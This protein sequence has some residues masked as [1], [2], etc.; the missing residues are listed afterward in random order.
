[1]NCKHA[2]ELFD[3]YIKKTASKEDA[4]ALEAHIA[5]CDS[6][7]KQLE[8]Y[9]FYFTDTNIEND[10]LVPSQLNAKIKYTIQQAKENAKNTKKIP[11]WQ[12][13]RIL[14]AATA[15]AFL[16]VAGILGVSNYEK[17]QNAAKTP[18][19]VETPVVLTEEKSRTSVPVAQEQM[20]E[21]VPTPQTVSVPESVSAP[22]AAKVSKN[23]TRVPE[24]NEKAAPEAAEL[25]VLADTSDEIQAYGSGGS[26]NASAEDTLTYQSDSETQS[27]KMQRNLVIAED[28]TLSF[29]Q[30]DAVL[31]AYPHEVI[32]DDLFLVTVTKAE[33]ETLLGSSVEADETKTQLVIRFIATEH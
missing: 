24:K 12:N 32:A 14:S 31:T 17:L 21:P 28:I 20:P 25:S 9:R 15:C 13:K 30:K 10:F 8:L 7:R 2:A 1:M 33:L 4:A 22:V 16:F 19:S 29:D 6:C 26:T 23:A 27:V 5:N 18:V 3:S 11:F